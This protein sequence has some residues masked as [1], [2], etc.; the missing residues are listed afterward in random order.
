MIDCMND[1]QDSFEDEKNLF[2][3]GFCFHHF[4]TAAAIAGFDF[5]LTVWE[6]GRLGVSNSRKKNR[7][8]YRVSLGSYPFCRFTAVC[9]Y[10]H[11][12][13]PVF[14]HTTC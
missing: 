7:G 5:C 13:C 3:G 6:F 11:Y 2:F 4:A 9:H 10:C 8:R 14:L 1:E 12:C